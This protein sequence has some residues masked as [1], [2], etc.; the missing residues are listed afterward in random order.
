VASLDR[1][2]RERTSKAQTRARGGRGPEEEV[3]KEEEDEEEEEEE[4]EEV[5]EEV[6]EEERRRVCMSL[7][8]A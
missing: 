5:E 4:E 7:E 6:L 1:Q 3:E 2:T 8:R